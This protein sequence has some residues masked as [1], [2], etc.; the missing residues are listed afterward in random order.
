[1][2]LLLHWF[3]SALALLATAYLVKGFEVKGFGSAL[4]AA[5]VIG[6]ANATLWWLLIILTLPINVLT[7]GLF[8]FVVNGAVLK[9]CAA[10]LP[11]FDIKSWM[12]AIFG[13]IIL[14]VISTILHY[15]LI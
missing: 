15:W 5:V 2:Q 9:I 13:S 11:G 6:L 14:T 10:F 3:V 12:A 4:L 7:L 8:T 1:M